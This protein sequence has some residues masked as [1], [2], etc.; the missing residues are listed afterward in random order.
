MLAKANVEIQLLCQEQLKWRAM[1]QPYKR[2]AV[3][4]YSAGSDRI[5]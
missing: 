3:D 4:V 5:H 2:K 1:K